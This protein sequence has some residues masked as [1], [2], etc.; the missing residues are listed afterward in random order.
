[1][2]FLRGHLSAGFGEEGRFLFLVLLLFFLTQ[3]LILLLVIVH[4]TNMHR[5]PI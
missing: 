3:Y 4:T 2:V 5:L 1:M